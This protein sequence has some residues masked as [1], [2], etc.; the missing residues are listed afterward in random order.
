MCGRYLLWPAQI[1]VKGGV[2]RFGPVYEDDWGKVKHFIEAFSP[3]I[4]PGDWK[5]YIIA[6]FPLGK[7]ISNKRSLLWK[8]MRAILAIREVSSTSAQDDVCDFDADRI[9]KVFLHKIILFH[10]LH[11]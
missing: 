2:E 4:A 9:K 1:K 6:D 5:E 8:Y 7:R 11:F 3:K 10:F